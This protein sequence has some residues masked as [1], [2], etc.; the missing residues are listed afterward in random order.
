MK[1]E[2]IKFI[3]DSEE[4][5]LTEDLIIRF[6][7]IFFPYKVSRFITALLELIDEG[8]IFYDSKDETWGV[9]RA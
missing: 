2:I 4:Y 7:D 3:L 8:K 9:A 1:A 5:P 6:C